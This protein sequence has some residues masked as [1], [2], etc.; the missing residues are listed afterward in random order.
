MCSDRCENPTPGVG[1]QCLFLALSDLLT[2]AEDVRFS[3]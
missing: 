1:W 2:G 3:G